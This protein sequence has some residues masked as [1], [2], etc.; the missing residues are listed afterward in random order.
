MSWPDRSTPVTA[1]AVTVSDPSERPTDY[2]FNEEFVSPD[3]RQVA[4]FY[5]HFRSREELFDWMRHRPASAP[6]LREIP[7][8]RDVVVVVPTADFSGPM[9]AHCRDFVFRGLHLIFVE[10]PTR[11]DPFFNY[12]SYYNAGIRRALERGA[13]WVVISGDDVLGVDAPE[14]LLDGLAR[15]DPTRFDSVFTR[16]S[17]YYHSVE[18]QLG[19]ERWTRRLAFSTSSGR[20]A[21]LALERRFFVTLHS[22]R[23]RGLDTLFFRPG[24]RYWSMASF[25]IFSP[26]YLAPL[27]PPFDPVFGSAGSE[28]IELCLRVNRRPERIA[29]VD[30]RISERVGGTAGKSDAR[31]LREVAGKAYLN[32][33]LREQPGNYFPAGYDYRALL[34]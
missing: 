22:P 23:A 10:S 24:Y 20:R 4:R 21:A 11:P 27:D 31:R 18:S 28:D 34:A 15:T 26:T 14:K 9:A 16:P 13:R 30:Y 3:A 32:H 33:V 29:F 5:E 7:G 8:N 1:A 17:G 25:G 19:R 6:Q 12:S 2:P